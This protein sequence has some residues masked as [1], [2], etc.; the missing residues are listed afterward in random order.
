MI[1]LY[2]L[3]PFLVSLRGNKTSKTQST[4]VAHQF[5]NDQRP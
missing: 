5:T 3:F 1:S 2:R 4:V